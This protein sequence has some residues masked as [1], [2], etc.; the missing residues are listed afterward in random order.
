MVV[1]VVTSP[2]PRYVDRRDGRL[3]RQH[4]D[5][6]GWHAREV[7]LE[8]MWRISKQRR[9]LQPREE[10]LVVVLDGGGDSGK[11][12]RRGDWTMKIPC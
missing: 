6:S 12:R 2:S 3:Q 11:P 1:P 8:R 10:V 5:E 4:E 9:Q 7:W